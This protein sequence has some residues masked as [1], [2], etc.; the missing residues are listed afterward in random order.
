M[1]DRRQR[2]RSRRGVGLLILTVLI[3]SGCKDQGTAPPLV[4][5]AVQLP[6]GSVVFFTLGVTYQLH[7]AVVDQNG[8]TMT[9]HTITWSSS[10]PSV[11]TVSGSGL[12]QAV[13]NGSAQVTAR[14]GGLSRGPF[15]VT[16]SQ[17]VIELRKVAGDA[18]IGTAGLPLPVPITVQALDGGGSPIPGATVK[19][20]VTQGGGS[21][22]APS[23][24]TTAA[25]L[26]AVT[27]T[28]GTTAGAAQVV[29]VSADRI[30]FVQH[31]TPGNYPD[32]DPQ[33]F[34]ATA[35]P[36][37]TQGFATVEAGSYHTC[38]RTLSGTGSCWGYGGWGQLGNGSTASASVPQPVAG[39]QTFAASEVG[40]HHS[41]GLMASGE[42]SCWGSDAYGELG[43]GGP[44]P[45]VCTAPDIGQF[46]CSVVPLSVVGGLA[47]SSMSAGWEGHCGLTANGAANCWGTN[48]NGALGIGGDT[49]T[50]GTCVLGPCSR[51]PR[52]V[53]GGHT[54]TAIG[55]G[56][57][58]ACGLATTGAVYCWGENSTGQLG[59]ARTRRRTCADRARAAAGSS[60]EDTRSPDSA[61]G[62][63]IRAASRPAACGTAGARTTTAS[64]APARL[65]RSCA[66]GRTHATVCPRRSLLG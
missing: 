46:R 51:T 13:A 18:Q 38:G 45:E 7:A 29:T 60:P 16:V 22:S 24:V 2:H 23:V 30:Q 52:A 8:D 48:R 9:G 44:G 12:V 3:S 20:A 53:T 36:A 35:L 66:R 55:V 25:G 41:C 21:V 58:H 1:H 10:N 47:F 65:G 64:W 49:A 42:I 14:S 34:D 63:S 26:A 27:W 43:A 15:D 37:G 40:G 17:E 28:L 31:P 50:L 61:S 56:A 32:P 11:A 62:C 4:P 5:A 39:G 59:S 19:F 33:T 57:R 6:P 54:F